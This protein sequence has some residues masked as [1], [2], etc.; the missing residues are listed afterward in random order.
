MSIFVNRV[1][2]LKKIKAIGFDMDYTIVR[3][4]TEN[5]EKLT[6][7]VVLQKLVDDENY[8]KEILDL[9]FEF[10]RA[11]RGLV[12]DE[13]Y[14]NIIKMSLYGRI[15]KAYHGLSEI[16]FKEVNRLYR[17]E[18]VDLNDPRFTP[19]D[20]AF[21]IA[22][23]VLFSQ[24]VECRDKSPDK[25]PNYETIAADVLRQIDI[26][27]RDNSLKSAVLSNLDEYIIQDPKIV[28]SLEKLKDSGKKLFIVTNSDYV[29]TQKLLDYTFTPHLKNHK[30]W[31]ELFDIVTTLASKPYFFT[32]RPY[33]LKLDSNTQQLV[34]T[35]S[36]ENGELY[37]GG[38]A[39][40]L[41]EFFKV[42]GDEIL[43]LGDHIYGDI[44]ALKK[45]CNWRT[46]L[47]LEEIDKERELTKTA[48]NIILEIDEV[49]DSKKQIEDKIDK[50]YMNKN[51]NR[52]EI[53]KL[54]K[55]IR[56]I[57]SQLE[58]LIGEYN[59]HFNPYWGEVMRA[60]VE[61]SRFAGQVAKYACIYMAK[62]SDLFEYSPRKYFR[63]PR[64]LL[65]HDYN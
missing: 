29:Y 11:I 2:N 15:K 9:K 36:L 52:E 42:K 7:T 39:I 26:A 54:F 6:H 59:Y 48:S 55:M 32:A 31:R 41:E 19:V 33:F 1:L 37:Q 17:G 5:F 25:Y 20:T 34:N 24:L 28:W 14:G 65:P 13:T 8:P 61:E 30:D 43:Y 46:A 45:E 27:H 56:D 38:N 3:Y 47:V 57:D 18:I 40:S 35:E 16:P 51:K 22:H 53:D 12:I 58:E 49:M 4:Q 64:R 60:G 21:S 63:P 62:V 44:V 10:N 23:A 50:L